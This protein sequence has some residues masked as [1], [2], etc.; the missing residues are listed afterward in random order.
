MAELVEAR[1]DELSTVAR[2]TLQDASVIGLRFSRRLLQRVATIPTSLD[3]ALAELVEEELVVPGDATDDSPVVVPEPPGPGGRLRSVLR[4]RRPAAH[5]AV[6][7]ALLELEPDRIRENAEL[8]AHHFEEGDDP[9]L[10]VGHLLVA[11]D[12]AEAAFNLVGA[13]DRARRALRLRD[14][15]AGRVT[16]ADAA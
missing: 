10:A 8:L 15:F 6:A 12:R 3:A 13:L 16:D 7:E 1:I 9:P 4:R 11:I 14:R 2:V 5:R